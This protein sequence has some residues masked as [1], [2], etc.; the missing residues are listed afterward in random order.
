MG[1]DGV[2]LTL[3]F[4]TLVDFNLEWKVCEV[5]EGKIKLYGE[6][7]NRVVMR[8]G[9]GD[10]ET[11]LPGTLT[12][13]LRECGWIIKKVANQD[14]EIDRL[15][16][17]AFEFQAEG[18]VTLS[19]GTTTSTGTWEVAEGA[20]GGLV[21][22]ITMGDEPGVSFE[23][24]LRDLTNDRLKFEAPEIGYELILERV[25][26]SVADG[27]VLEIS[28]ILMGGDW[29]VAS[30]VDGDMDETSNFAGF[31]FSF[32]MDQV[33]TVSTNMDPL[34]TGLWRV[35]R[36][37]EGK[38]KVYLNLGDGDDVFAD[39]TDDWDFVSVTAN[40]LELK[41]ISGDGTVTTLVFEK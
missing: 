16:G 19:N 13:I 40:R 32:G 30:Y 22:A 1:D 4:D 15:I 25:C 14:V 6:E 41:D 37:S 18:V 26:A 10:P 34:T 28:N 5:G 38:L 35:V 11:I 36:D 12:E 2:L 27:D 33:L 23:W 24:P 8:S 9:C 20:N 17:Y 21:L 29:T 3:A 39:L 7:G 31:D